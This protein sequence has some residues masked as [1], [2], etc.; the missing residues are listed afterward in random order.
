VRKRAERAVADGHVAL[1][2]ARVQAVDVPGVVRVPRPGRQIDEQPR[3]VVDQDQQV[4][5]REAAAGLRPAGLA[6][7][8]LQRGRVGHG[9]PG[10]VAQEHA[11]A[12]PQRCL[13]RHIATAGDQRAG[14]VDEQVHRQAGSGVAEGGDAEAHPGEVAE[15][16]AG[17]V[18][19]EDL[20]EHE[21]D[22]RH[23]V[24]RALTPAVPDGDGGVADQCRIETSA[25]VALEPGDGGGDTGGHP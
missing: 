8:L 2:Q 14:E 9:D 17:A 16:A 23:R 3:G 4:H 20:Q 22:G 10:A 1:A 25:R 13:P 6:E 15:R 18:A 12:E 5:D 24:E 7:G 11:V 21:A 19:V